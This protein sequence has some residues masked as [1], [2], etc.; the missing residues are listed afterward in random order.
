MALGAW[1]PDEADGL[2]TG[3]AGLLSE[4]KAQEPE[5]TFLSD[6]AVRW[7]KM[8]LGLHL[9]YVKLIPIFPTAV[10][11]IFQMLYKSSW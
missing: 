6:F 8:R 3:Q 7:M 4:K 9:L 10:F 11:P 2:G 5:R 1:L